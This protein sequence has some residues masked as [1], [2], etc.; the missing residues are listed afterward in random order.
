MI[1]RLSQAIINLKITQ[2]K[3]V[4]NNNIMVRQLEG[5]QMAKEMKK[6]EEVETLKGDVAFQ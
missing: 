4:K 5:Q 6:E 2:E 3:V 1:V